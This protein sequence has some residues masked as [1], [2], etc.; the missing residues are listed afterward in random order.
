MLMVNNSAVKNEFVTLE[1][2]F[3]DGDLTHQL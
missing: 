3:N 2:I 1:R